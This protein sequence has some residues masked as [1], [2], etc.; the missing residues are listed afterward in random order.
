MK[1]N[2]VYALYF[3]LFLAADTGRGQEKKAATD[4]D[5]NA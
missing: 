1:A 4:I 5:P 3:L 2:L